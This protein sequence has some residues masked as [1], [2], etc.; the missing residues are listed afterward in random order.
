MS[1][2]FDR[3]AQP[4]QSVKHLPTPQFALQTRATSWWRGEAILSAFSIPNLFLHSL[5][6]LTSIDRETTSLVDD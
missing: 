1:R 5:I 2:L 4:S 6:H 3:R